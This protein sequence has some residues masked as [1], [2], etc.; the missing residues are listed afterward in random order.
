MSTN[1]P[2]AYGIDLKRIWR[3]FISKIW[4][5]IIVTVAGTAIGLAAYGIYSNVKSGNTLY[6][7]RN[8]YYIYLDYDNFP[9][10]PDYYNAYT[11]DG[12]LRDDPIVNNVLAIA[13]D[14]TKQQVLD[15][16]KG[17]ILGDYRLLTVIVTGT[18]QSLVQKI[19]DAYKQAMPQFADKIDMILDI[20]LWT[21]A[22]MEVYD[23]YTKDANAAF[24]GGLI[25]LL[26][27]I[28][29]IL[30]YYVVDDGI[31][32]ERDWV[33]R[34]PDIPD[35]GEAGSKEAEI[36]TEHII[37]D[38]SDCYD[39]NI[40]DFE[41]NRDTFDKMRSSDGVILHV[42]RGADKGEVIDKVVYTLRKQ[43]VKIRGML[44]EKT[45]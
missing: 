26:I 7:I 44:V 43:E 12:I 36:N 28:F 16:V 32:S 8:D 22:E 23:A 9:E 18:D 31:Y 40:K 6:R 13:P 25:G 15:S 14:V 1:N 38:T 11:W 42:R 39:L 19:S 5:V 4:I 37:K 10:G 41:F 2:G 35:L 30:I 20:E 34:Y 3:Q 33:S 21:D 27:S 45:R 17:E 29:G 24:L